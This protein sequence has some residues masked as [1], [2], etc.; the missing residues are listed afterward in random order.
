MD[1]S[2]NTDTHLSK[3]F[4]KVLQ[5]CMVQANMAHYVLMS[6]PHFFNLVPYYSAVEGFF[7]NTFYLF[8]NLKYNFSNGKEERLDFA[9]ENTMLEI[10][11]KM[12][13]MKYDGKHI[14]NIHDYNYLVHKCKLAHM[15]I[16]TGLNKRNMLVRQSE[17]EPKGIDSIGYWQ[18]KAMF[19]KG[20][21]TY[22]NGG[23]DGQATTIQH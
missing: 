15:M 6:S 2:L 11:D 17:R 19:R 22:S 21:L 4:N 1:T 3:D 10:Q 8:S 20:D 7:I 14:P 18:E 9:L 5:G 12:T 16:M 23:K 13:A